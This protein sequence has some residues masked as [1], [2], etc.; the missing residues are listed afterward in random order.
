MG[1]GWRVMRGSP[2]RAMRYDDPA[3]VV[4]ADRCVAVRR[5]CQDW[6]NWRSRPTARTAKAPS[7]IGTPIRHNSSRA[8]H[9]DQPSRTPPHVVAMVP[10]SVQNQVRSGKRPWLGA[11]CTAGRG[12]FRRSVDRCLLPGPPG[13][14]A[15]IRRMSGRADPS[16]ST[17]RTRPMCCSCSSTSQFSSEGGRQT[18][19]KGITSGWDVDSA[20]CDAGSADPGT[21]RRLVAASATAGRDAVGVFLRAWRAGSRN[22]SPHRGQQYVPA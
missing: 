12:R 21:D 13:W 6:S 7:V 3:E 9:A 20:G 5:C 16:S 4:F 10:S 17:A 19:G 11:R 18:W 1:G 22:A 14:A 15:S 2:R 8:V